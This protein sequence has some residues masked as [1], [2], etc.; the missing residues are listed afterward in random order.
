MLFNFF[1]LRAAESGRAVRESIIEIINKTGLTIEGLDFKE[2]A[3]YI[4]LNMT[5]QEIDQSC[6]N[7]E[8]QTWSYARYDW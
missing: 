4:R 8:K 3:K 5:D 2:I 6:P 7:Q 1:S